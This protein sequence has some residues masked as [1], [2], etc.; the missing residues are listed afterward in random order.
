[1]KI[2][3]MLRKD[4]ITASLKGQTKRDVLL[5]MSRTVAL[6]EPVC[7]ADRIVEVLLEREKLGSTG[8]GDG[9]A[10]PHGKLVELENMVIGFGRSLNGI[11]FN[12]MDGR[13]V[14]LFFL[15]LAPESST[16]YHLKALARVSKML[17]DETFRRRLLKA[18]SEDE[19]YRIIEEK[20]E[21]F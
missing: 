12:A 2:M 18:S 3:D 21:V 9:I 6:A 15:L 16:G 11:D 19:I 14:H 4:C 5:E 8:I 17:K 7:D 20:D 1:M 13:P 10:I